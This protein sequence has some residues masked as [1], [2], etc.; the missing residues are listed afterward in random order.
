MGEAKKPAMGLAAKV[1]L[2]FVGSAVYLGLAVLGWGGF[3]AFF[4]H[5]ALIALTAVFF[6]Q[7]CAA[8][9]AGGNLSPGVREDRS[10]R[11][12]IAALVVNGLL[13]GFLAAYTDRK[14]FWVIDGDTIRWVGVVL[15]AVGGTLRLWPV[16]VLGERF[17]GYVAIQPE[18]T[19]VTDNVYSAIRNPSYLGLL[20]GSLGWGFAFRSGVGVV[21]TIL[22][23][24]PVISRTRS[25]EKLLG[26]EFGDAYDAYCGHTSRL[27]PRVY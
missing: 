22:L 8:F 21:L 18:H 24:P 3:R 19:L 20:V 10:N 27:I 5:P 2:V 4:S 26:E 7:A 17:S 11:W 13:N 9:F 12:V 15:A 16:F 6:V 14:E 23:I 1:L 25:E